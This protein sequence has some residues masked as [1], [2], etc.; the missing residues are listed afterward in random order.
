MKILIVED[1]LAMQNLFEECLEDYGFKVFKA[2]TVEE[3]EKVFRE[4]PDL[5]IITF[6]GN[7]GNGQGETVPLVQK[8]RPRFKG[9][10]IAASSSF[11]NQDEL[12]TAGCD[13][14]VEKGDLVKFLV[15]LRKL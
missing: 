11:L 1:D 14:E 12:V 15:E 10:M 8:I 2:A 9:I 6:D 3:A 4:N 7:L 13:Y 5:K